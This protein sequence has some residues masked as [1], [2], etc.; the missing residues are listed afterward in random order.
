MR[1]YKSKPVEYNG[2]RYASKL[3][4]KRAY[5]L[6]MLVK[7][8]EIKSWSPQVRVP[9]H[10]PGGGIVGYYVVDFLVTCNDGSCRYEEVKGYETALWKW[11]FR[12]FKQEYPDR[13]IVILKK[14]DI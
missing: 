11:K 9:L 6:D 3:E 12:H 8:G 7:A 4:A 5:Q 2:R 13:S 14:G 1:K 10:V